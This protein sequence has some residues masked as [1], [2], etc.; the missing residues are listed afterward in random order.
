MDR[1]DEHHKQFIQHMRQIHDGIVGHRKLIDD[2]T[3]ALIEDD[4]HRC[5]EI[6]KLACQSD[7]N[8][9]IKIT[10]CLLTLVCEKLLNFRQAHQ[11]EV[12]VEE[13]DTVVTAYTL[14][15][16]KKSTRKKQITFKY[17]ATNVNNYSSLYKQNRKTKKENVCIQKTENQT[18]TSSMRVSLKS[19]TS[20]FTITYILSEKIFSE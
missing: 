9:P 15:A 6:A 8:G 5:N 10:G 13:K 16:T 20:L 12:R 14:P 2:C 18:K 11:H 19:I 4:Y 1:R 17:C 7:I 3:T